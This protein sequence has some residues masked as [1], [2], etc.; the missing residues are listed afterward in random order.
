MAEDVG[1]AAG[2]APGASSL[3]CSTAYTAP[4]GPTFS[5]TSANHEATV[6]DTRFAGT[7]QTSF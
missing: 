2:A 6:P 4:S 1:S 7:D 5:E 3:W